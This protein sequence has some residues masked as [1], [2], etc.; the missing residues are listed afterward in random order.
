MM[1]DELLEHIKTVYHDNY[2]AQNDFENSGD[3]P[4][5]CSQQLHS[6]K[7]FTHRFLWWLLGV[8]MIVTLFS[9]CFAVAFAL[10]HLIFKITG[11]PHLI[12]TSIITG[13][14]GL[15]LFILIALFSRYCSKLY[16]QKYPEKLQ[17][18]TSDN[19]FLKS[20]MEALDRISQGDFNILIP[21]E[22]HHPFGE[23]AESVNRMAKELSSMEK[24]RQDFISNV[25]HEIQS[26]LTSIGGFAALLKSE[27]LTNEQRLHYAEIIETETKRLSGLSTNLLKLSS[28]EADATPLT[29]ET[30]R[31]DKQI[32]HAIL[33]LEPQWLKKNLTP[34]LDLEKT[35]FT[36]DKE[37]LSQVW[38][39]LLH[40]AIKFTPNEGEFHITLSF[41]EKEIICKIAD[42]GIGISSEDQVHV[43][44]RFYK[45]DKAR[46]RS[47]GG[48]GL[49]LSLVQK[50]VELHGGRIDLEST[51]AVGTTFT[52][53]LPL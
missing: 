17:K 5:K 7:K 40:N 27:T 42:S 4:T 21:I 18:R 38:I 37:L 30:F 29:L 52:I 51:L 16:Y 50:I 31:L 1:S 26:P 11:T 24:V 10:L 8:T 53:H 22:T 6:D 19:P 46:D 33:M 32:E 34:C 14:L 48:N 3:M 45:V 39:N 43:F 44:E 28:L 9:A 49:G 20:T 15:I 35:I 25:S 36:G 41:D 2:S 47:L 23:V 12:A 13:I